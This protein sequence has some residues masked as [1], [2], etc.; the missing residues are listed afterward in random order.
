MSHE[1]GTYLGSVRC[2][3]TLRG[4]CTMDKDSDCWH[5]RTASGRPMPRVGRHGLWLNGRGLMTATRA[6]WLLAHG[7]L[8]TQRSMVVYRACDSYDCVNP[9][10]LKAGLR[11]ALVR[12]RMASGAMDTPAR[13]AALEAFKRSR[14]TAVAVTAELRLW[15]AQSAQSGVDAAHGLGVSQSRANALRRQMRA[16]PNS[17]FAMGAAA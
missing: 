16:R 9:K 11:T 14:P 6:A 15:L 13:R 3:E 17:V 8:P 2:L 10:H 1:H 5:L 7:S 12:S 4:R